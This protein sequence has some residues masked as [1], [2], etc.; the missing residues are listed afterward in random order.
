MTES[1]KEFIYGAEGSGL[2]FKIIVTVNNDGSLSASVQMLEGTMDLNALWFSDGDST[3]NESGTTKL[4]KADSALNMNGATYD[5]GDDGT[6]DRLA[7]DGVQ[8]LSSAG[9]GTEGEE[10][11]TFLAAGGEPLDIPLSFNGSLDD[12]DYIGVRATSVN[13]GDSI[14]LIDE[15][16]LITPPPPE[17]D[18]FPEWS[19]PAISHVTFYFNTPDGFEFDTKGSGGGGNNEPDGW[20]TVKFDVGGDAGNEINDMDNWYQEALDLIYSQFGD[21]SAYLEGVAIKGGQSGE[22]W[23]DLDNDPGDIDVAPAGIP[24]YQIVSN[25]LDATGTVTTDNTTVE[26]DDFIF[27]L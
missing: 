20:F 4:D 15:G 18:H 3:A 27:T 13:G 2:Y 14:K 23:Y 22:V 12:L 5:V 7:W 19:Q 25:E 26:Q 8:K 10:K 1:Y 24:G 17:E 9:L 6:Q 21:L 16:E 11:S